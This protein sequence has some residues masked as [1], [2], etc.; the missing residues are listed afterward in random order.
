[1]KSLLCRLL[2]IYGEVAQ[3]TTQGCSRH[4]QWDST[5]PEGMLSKAA[6]KRSHTVTQY[7]QVLQARKEHHFLNNHTTLPRSGETRGARS[8]TEALN[9]KPLYIRVRACVQGAVGVDRTGRGQ[10]GLNQWDHSC[11]NYLK[12]QTAL[13]WTV[14]LFDRHLQVCVCV[15]VVYLPLCL[16]KMGLG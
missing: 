2:V 9:I 10:G 5:P 13:K 4:S 6:V 12:Y 7:C 16:V 8:A 3:T 11:I 15:C 1:M 14:H